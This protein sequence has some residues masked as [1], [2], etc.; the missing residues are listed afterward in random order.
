MKKTTNYG[1]S[2]NNALLIYGMRRD[3]INGMQEC[4][5]K[6]KNN[7]LQDFQGMLSNNIQGLRDLLVENI[8]KDALLEKVCI[9]K[10]QEHPSIGIIDLIEEHLFKGDRN[11]K[12]VYHRTM[13]HGKHIGYFLFPFRVE[14]YATIISIERKLNAIFTTIGL[15][16]T[17]KRH[18]FGGNSIEDCDYVFKENKMKTRYEKA[19]TI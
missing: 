9:R 12:L 17:V 7:S 2:I 6:Q 11:C 4:L 8:K 10:G 5:D 16:F 14:K 15:E 13:R 19:E 3:A 1:A 18:R